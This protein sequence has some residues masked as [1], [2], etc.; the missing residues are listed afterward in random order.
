ML[1]MLYRA[2]V[3]IPNSLAVSG[4]NWM[5]PVALDFSIN[6]KCYH[7]TEENAT[8]TFRCCIFIGIAV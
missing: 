4:I 5:S 2:V 8:I 1:L 6:K 7:L 3:V